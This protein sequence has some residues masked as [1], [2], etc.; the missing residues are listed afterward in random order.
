M[1]MPS[2][3]AGESLVRHELTLAW[4]RKADIDR[5]GPATWVSR[6]SARLSTSDI[7]F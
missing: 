1:L 4:R 6:S 5:S 7:K 2:G 3:F